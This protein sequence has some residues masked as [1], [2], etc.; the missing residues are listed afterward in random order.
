MSLALPNVVIIVV[1]FTNWGDHITASTIALHTTIYSLHLSRFT[2]PWATGQPPQIRVMA[3]NSQSHCHLDEEPIQ[4]PRVAATASG[5]L[6]ILWNGGK[7]KQ[8]TYL[9]QIPDI[10]AV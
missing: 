4:F 5:T 8:G 1:S 3:H 10:A 6:Q 7:I 2:I 9:M